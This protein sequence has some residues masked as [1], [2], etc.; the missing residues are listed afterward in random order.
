V[1][2]EMHTL[3]EGGRRRRLST[4]HLVL[5]QLRNLAAEGNRKAFRFFHKLEV[6]YN[7]QEET[8]RGGFLVVSE[9]LTLEE[10]L[11][12]YGKPDAD[13]SSEADQ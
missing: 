5:L 8:W 13:D 6:K 10:W 4:L 11:E 1:A 9:P 12:R 3:V 2:S 7:P